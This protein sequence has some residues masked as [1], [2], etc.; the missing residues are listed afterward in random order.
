FSLFRTFRVYLIC[1][2]LR[3][4]VS[5]KNGPSAAPAEAACVRTPTGGSTSRCRPH[6]KLMPGLPVRPAE[7]AVPGQTTAPERGTPPDKFDPL[8]VP[9][10]LHAKAAPS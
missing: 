8:I 9:Y 7:F 6:Q 10:I 5:K 2:R 4:D 1:P 3:R